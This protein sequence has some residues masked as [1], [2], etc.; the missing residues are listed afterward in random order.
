MVVRSDF[1]A[2]WWLANPHLQTLWPRFMRRQAPLR[3]RAERL[4]L[5]DGDF[6]DL[7]W[8]DGGKGP[9]VCIL[10]GL[11]GGAASPYAQGILT[12]IADRGWH[13][14][15]MHFRGC[16]GELNRL[17][18]SY[19]SGETGD[20]GH[21]L[22]V[23]RRRYPGVAV[24]AVGY[25]LGGNVLLKY[26]GERGEA[27]GLSAA[28]AVS[29]PFLLSESADR[30]D[31]GFSRFYQRLLLTSLK[32]KTA[33]KFRRL[34]SPVPLDG[35]AGCRN[36]REFDDRVTAPLHGFTDA[37]D[38]Y[39]RSSSRQFLRGIT[40]PT[41]ILQAADDPLMTPAVI[42]GDAELAPSVRL[43]LS[44]R[45]G[46]VGFVTGSRPWAARYWLEERIPAFLGE[47]LT[48]A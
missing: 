15:L 22:A 43:E 14:V 44:C 9:V 24:A 28:A 25:S 13:G 1:R 38:Y 8:T 30:L 46:H 26:L 33:A 40:V 20:M 34:K 17:P 36:F 23:I 4:E 21:F 45:G 41:L 35:V 3:L 10:H 39:A 16:G 29:V 42:P 31:R 37:A 12:A 48:R 6:V 5:P 32:M 11:E 27:A 7:A 47:H 2:A 19:H 18:R